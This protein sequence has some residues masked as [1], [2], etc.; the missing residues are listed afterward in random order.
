MVCGDLIARSSK[1]AF[2]INAGFLD[3]KIKNCIIL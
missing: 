1:I 3:R 2:D